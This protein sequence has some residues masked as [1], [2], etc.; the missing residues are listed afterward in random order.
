MLAKANTSS[1]SKPVGKACTGIGFCKH[2]YVET[3]PVQARLQ[4]E[5]APVLSIYGAVNYMH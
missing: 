3:I 5:L 4:G 1:A 2:S